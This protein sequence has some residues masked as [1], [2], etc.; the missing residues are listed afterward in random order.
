MRFGL[1]SV[2]R[3]LCCLVS[4]VA[5]VAALVVIGSIPRFV[6]PLPLY[7]GIERIDVGEYGAPV[8]ADWNGDGAKDLVCG[9][10][11]SGRMRFY[12]NLGSD[13]APVFDGYSFLR[14]DGSEITLPSV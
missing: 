12:P 4:S 14:A 6:G 5:A 1:R 7:D 9:Q 10:F 2:G 11:D 8:M 3:R 13:S